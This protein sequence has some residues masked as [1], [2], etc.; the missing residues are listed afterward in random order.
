M[1]DIYYIQRKVSI[2]QIHGNVIAEQPPVDG[3]AFHN[4]LFHPIAGDS[5]PQEENGP[6]LSLRSLQFGLLDEDLVNAM[7]VA[8]ITSA[9][10]TEAPGSLCDGRM[11]AVA[12][13]GRPCRTCGQ[14]HHNCPVV[15]S[16]SENSC[17]RPG[18]FGQIRLPYPVVNPLFVSLLVTVMQTICVNCQRLRLSPFYIQS[19]P[20]SVIVRGWG[21]PQPCFLNVLVHCI[22]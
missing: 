8:T 13:G 16:K 17:C 10:C 11:G 21:S 2:D 5:R 9:Q 3:R 6:L 20:S 12:G 14:Q 18:H 22:D 19:I 15:F 7:S 1:E 4:L